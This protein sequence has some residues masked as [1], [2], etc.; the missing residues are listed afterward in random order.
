MMMVM[1]MM[2]VDCVW[3]DMSWFRGINNG[4]IRNEMNAV[5][6]AAHH[7]RKT[8]TTTTTTPALYELRTESILQR[9]KSPSGC[10]FSGTWWLEESCAIINIPIVV[11]FFLW[12]FFYT[13]KLW[14]ISSE[15]RASEFILVLWED[16]QQAVK[17]DPSS[18]GCGANSV[19]WKV[20]SS[21]S[22]RLL[23]GGGHR[24]I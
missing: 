12:E 11:R 6:R 9:T 18:V 23:D 17:F 24:N 1:T 16:E 7:G 22:V 15:Q 19:N 13:L 21:V 2:T 5:F 8:T 4:S 20:E 10:S 3:F 14:F